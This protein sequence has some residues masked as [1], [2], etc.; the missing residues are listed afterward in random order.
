MTAGAVLVI[1]ALAAG[2]SAGLIWLLHPLLVRYA[3]ARPNGRSSHVA[4]TPQGGGI[5][6]IAATLIAA[7]MGATLFTGI[8]ARILVLFAAA[9]LLAVIGAVDDI[10]TMRPLPRLIIQFVAV[11]IV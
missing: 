1:I 6:V 8:D 3:L 4:P 7:L 11:G 5:G 9:V 10:V 2:L